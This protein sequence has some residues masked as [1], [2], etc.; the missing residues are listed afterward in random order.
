[1]MNDEWKSG[2]LVFQFII[3]RSSFITALSSL[4]MLRALRAQAEPLAQARICV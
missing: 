3:H 4:L 2:A 1:M